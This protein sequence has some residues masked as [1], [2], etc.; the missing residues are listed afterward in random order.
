MKS[1]EENICETIEYY[2]DKAI[3]NLDVDKTVTGKISKVIDADNGKYQVRYQGMTFIADS[4][5]SS[6]Q[7][8]VGTDIYV[9]MHE[10]NKTILGAIDNKE[11]TYSSKLQPA[12][13]F[14]L[15]GIKIGKGLSI[16][17]EGV[18]T[19]NTDD[20]DLSEFNEEEREKIL[21][22]IRNVIDGNYINNILLNDDELLFNELSS[23]VINVESGNIAKITANTIDSNYITT[24]L[25][26]AEEGD[27]NKVSARVVNAEE[28]NIKDLTANNVT[29]DYLNAKVAELGYLDADKAD[30]NYAKI[31]FENVNNSWI[32]NGVIKNAAI[33]NEMVQDISANKL[34]AGTLDAS[35]VTVSNLNASNITTG[36][37]TVGGLTINVAES[38]AEIDGGTA[39]KDGSITLSGLSKEVTDAIDGAIETFTTNTIPT[40][41]NY[42][43]SGWKSADYAKHVGDIC[44]VVNPVSDQDGFSYRFANNKLASG[45][46]NYEWILIK[47]SDVTKA[48]Q[49]LVDMQGD[50][51]GLKTFES[52]TNSWIESTDEELSSV[53]TR[54]TTIETTYSTKTEAQG[55]ASTAKS[56]AISSANTTAQGYANTAKSEAISSANTTA[57]GYANTAKSEA[58]SAAAADAKTKADGA[59]AD[60]KTYADQVV[61]TKVESSVFNEVKQTVDENSASITSMSDTLSKKADSSTVT[62]LSQTVNS[63]KQTT[64]SNTASITNLTTSVNSAY[65]T[66][67]IYYLATNTSKGVTTSTPGWTTTIQTVTAENRFLWTYN[68]YTDIGG[69]T[70]NSTPV[71][72]G[73]YGDTG[74]QGIAGASEWTTTVAPT[75]P[76]YTFTIANLSG[77]SA[78]TPAVGDLVFY[79]YYRYTITSVG[80]TT[81]L[82]GNR[83]SLRGATGA[84]GTGITSVT[85]L[86]YASNSQTAPAAPTAQVI[87]DDVTKY[88]QWNK[89]VPPYTTT[90]R[91]FYTCSEVLYSDNTRKWTNVARD[92]A[93]ETANATAESASVKAATVEQSLDGFKTTVSNTYQTKDAMSNYSTTEQM[94]TAITQSA[95]G[96]TSEVSKTYSTKTEAQGYATTAQSNAIS[97][98]SADATDKANT[99]EANAKADTT[100]KLKSYST[101]TQMNSAIS[102]SAGEITSTVNA[103]T[104][105][106][107]DSIEVGARNLIR[108]TDLSR[109]DEYKTKYSMTSSGVS[110]E[111]GKM[112]LTSGN[113]VQ[114]YAFP[115]FQ[116]TPIPIN[117]GDTLTASVY[118]YENTLTG[119]SKDLRL[120]IGYRV[121]GDTAQRWRYKTFTQNEVGLLS[122]TWTVDVDDIEYIAIDPQL[123]TSTGG[124]VVLGNYMLEKGNKA[125]T[126]T[127]APED[128]QSQIDIHSS[129]I[130]QNADSIGLVVKSGSTESSLTLTD[131]ALSAIAD[132]IILTGTTTFKSALNKTIKTDTLYYLATTASSGVTTSTSGW[133]TTTQSVTADKRYLWTYH[134][135]TYT[136]GTTSNS[137]PVI[138]GVWGNTGSK[139]DTGTSVTISSTSVTYQASTSGT[140]TPT[141]TWSTTVPTVTKGQYL[142]TKTVVTYST[143]TSTTSYSVAYEGTNGNNGNDGATI[144]TTTVAPVAP[145]YTFTISN[146]TGN[147]GTPKVGDLIVYSY[148]RYTITSVDTTTVL[149]GSRTSIRGA[150]GAAGTSVSITSTETTYQ[151][152]NSATT[153]PTGTWDVN[154]PTTSVA[155]PYLWTKTYVLYSTGSS[156]TSYGVSSTTDSIEIG[157]RNLIQGGD[158]EYTTAYDSAD[159]GDGKGYITID[160]TIGNLLTNTDYTLSLDVKSSNGT[161][162]F[163]ASLAHNNSSRVYF[164]RKAT[165]TSTYQRMSFVINTTT[166][167]DLN[168]I[169]LA[170]GA[171]LGTNTGN[172]GTVYYKNIKL[173]KGN[174]AT[175][176]TPAPE[177]NI[178]IQKLYYLKSNSTAPSKPTAEVTSVAVGSGAWTTVIPNP[179]ANYYYFTCDQKKD[180]VGTVTWT[181]VVKLNTESTLL[182]WCADTDVT[183]IDGGKIYANSVTSAKIDVT[184]LF[185][186]NIT[187]TN[188]NL[189]G[190]SIAVDTTDGT[191]YLTL[192]G[193]ESADRVVTTIKPNEISTQRSME[194]IS[195]GVSIASNSSTSETDT[196]TTYAYKGHIDVTSGWGRKR[197]SDG[198][199]QKGGTTGSVSIDATEGIM[200]DTGG[201]GMKL[202]S[203]GVSFTGAVSGILQTRIGSI[204][205][206]TERV[207]AAESVTLGSSNKTDASIKYQNVDSTFT[208]IQFKRGDVYG[209]GIVIGAGGLTVIGGGESAQNYVD[210]GVTYSVE[211]LALTSDGEIG[212]L[213]NCQNIADR[214]RTYIDGTGVYH[215]ADILIPKD[216]SIIDGGVPAAGSI[217]DWAG[218]GAYRTFIGTELRPNSSQWMNMINLRH[219]NGHG[220]GANY[221]MQIYS[222]LTHNDSLKYQQQTG[223]TSGWQTARTILDTGNSAVVMGTANPQTN[224]TF[225]ITRP[226][227]ATRCIIW[228][229]N[230]YYG[231]SQTYHAPHFDYFSSLG[232]STNISEMTLFYIGSDS[233]T[234]GQG[235]GR[236]SASFSN[237]NMTLKIYKSATSASYGTTSTLYSV[238]WLP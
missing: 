109:W 117:R 131:S 65:K 97:T 126:W 10:G 11:I 237:G 124:Y 63:V 129:E 77:S 107:F 31:N 156:T 68:K 100:E 105:T 220:D 70:T 143:G 201:D 102:Q 92:T 101:T 199:T 17:N 7:Y 69:N 165:T 74:S 53:K 157:G 72:T 225:T 41:N 142:W 47:D 66:T 154:I 75:T 58:I 122:Y 54:T 163:Y 207:Q 200:I 113:G 166:H 1:I 79:S 62:T 120:Y 42:P 90:Y 37:L 89:S 24:K 27:F 191:N 61:S 164:S 173:E 106:K 232:A 230:N 231:G 8:E 206:E 38:K 212:F 110:V 227:N 213:T 226:V 215:C 123:Y 23:K 2:V 50:I 84:T 161:D 155:N 222:D 132:N 238:Q 71:V 140:T 167:A 35:K 217:T 221:G 138:T 211:N 28:A 219:R 21:E 185:S 181:D 229:C 98:A 134:K 44:Y 188:F 12:T 49:D 95:S 209:A 55:Y 187:A 40:L 93:L 177:D 128:V 127:P 88:N 233:S 111:N 25:I 67:T 179:V 5:D 16:D 158:K 15:G 96:I 145:N 236:V 136:D 205:I 39:I 153:V 108:Y 139:G 150:T 223:S 20:I 82:T 176:W 189:T 186:Q 112:T 52:E 45:A 208:P 46:D 192:R 160:I 202:T 64:D 218:G 152:S 60:A 94:N 183:Q 33:T 171:T 193:T 48:L 57:Q 204:G 172:T 115:K 133:T 234:A 178:S 214:V 104:D 32:E 146:L 34:T 180:G 149:T 182:Q 14:K 43:A 99:A 194:T 103:Y 224:N 18:V 73:V 159:K 198:A 116:L 19:V 83:T 141:G 216:P 85:P 78:K 29:T 151:V 144:W 76:N 235:N 56:E 9:L 162:V 130:K 26:E 91:Y 137:S 4:A 184:D 210:L 125:T 147:T 51:S 119:G 148:Y 80:T 195:G 6:A 197:K 175:D 196:T 228:V 86:Y 203:N 13:R 118:V 36:T 190:G 174:K 170:S 87:V 59:L 168:R 22:I 135:Y 3:E 81:V 30:I 114:V 169:L 121:K